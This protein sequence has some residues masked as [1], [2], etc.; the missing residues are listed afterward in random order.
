MHIA[1]NMIFTAV[2]VKLRALC[3]IFS[4]YSLKEYLPIYILALTTTTVLATPIFYLLIFRE[5]LLS[6]P[7]VCLV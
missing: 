7:G 6:G 5:K 2:Y 1:R 4:G 3:I